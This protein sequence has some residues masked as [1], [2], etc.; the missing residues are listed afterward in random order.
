[1][2]LTLTEKLDV[3]GMGNKRMVVY[4][5]TGDGETRTIQAD[6]MKMQR[7]EYAYSVN[8][9]NPNFTPIVDYEAGPK[10]TIAFDD[11]IESGSKQLVICY[12][13]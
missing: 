1:M 12:G 3:S 11:E 5:I 4:E 9:D 7:I 6:Q 10:D 2:A 8:V 13:F